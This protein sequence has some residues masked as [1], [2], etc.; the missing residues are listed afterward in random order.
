MA[1]YLTAAPLKAE[2]LQ[3]P[4]PSKKID[5]STD[6]AEEGPKGSAVFG[7]RAVQQ[8][9]SCFQY[10][11]TSV[12]IS[13]SNC[14]GLLSSPINVTSALNQAGQSHLARE[15]SLWVTNIYTII[16]KLYTNITQFCTNF[17]KWPYSQRG[18]NSTI[19]WDITPCNPL[20]V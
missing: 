2:A 9:Q 8:N 19:F 17:Q 7:V 10:G 14:T 5:S 18:T 11:N 12:L 16:H 15:M 20:E 13:V 4:L 1:R 6:S 3:R